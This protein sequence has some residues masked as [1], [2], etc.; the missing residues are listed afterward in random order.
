M[1]AARTSNFSIEST[2]LARLQIN[3]QEIRAVYRKRKLHKSLD[4]CVR[5][6]YIQAPVWQI[7]LGL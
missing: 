5:W 1:A 2:A 6:L 4:L 7:R 3:R